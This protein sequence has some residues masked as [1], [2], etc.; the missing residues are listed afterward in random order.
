MK[1]KSSKWAV[2]LLA[3]ISHTLVAGVLQLESFTVDGDC[4]AANTNGY[5]TDS[6]DMAVE[7]FDFQVD[8]NISQESVRRA[9]NFQARVHV[10]AGYQVAMHSLIVEGETVIPQG[11]SARLWSK[12]YM[13]GYGE[14]IGWQVE[15]GDVLDNGQIA[16]PVGFSSFSIQKQTPHIRF[17]HCGEDVVFEGDLVI[18]AY[19][20]WNNNAQTSVVLTDAIGGNKRRIAWDWKVQP[21]QPDQA[22]PQKFDSHYS[23]GVQQIS[24]KMFLNGS[25]GTYHLANGQVGHLLNIQR[26]GHQLRGFWRL[27]GRTGW[28]EFELSTDLKSF[29]GKWGHGTDFTSPQGYWIGVASL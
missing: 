29:S 13:Q 18:D 7:F 14:A 26:F 28:F 12:Y 25:S 27:N 2:G 19:R 3:L 5:V 21:C 22:I 9:C 10:P 16:F 20:S 15:T 17:S 4:S 8:T 23:I 24:A 11:G 1:F 6:D